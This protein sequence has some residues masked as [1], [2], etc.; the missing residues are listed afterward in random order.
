MRRLVRA[1]FHIDVFLLN[2]TIGIRT[3]CEDWFGWSS[4]S[5]ER[6]LI[7]VYAVT[8]QNLLLHPHPSRVETSL[9]WLA[10]A[11][12]IFVS[13]MMWREQ[14]E[15]EAKRWVRLMAPGMTPL[16]V[17]CAGLAVVCVADAIATHDLIGDMPMVAYAAFQYML[18]IPSGGGRRGRKRKLALAKLR[19]MFGSWLPAPAGNPA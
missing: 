16:R 10:S 13:A 5:M 9:A 11:F 8:G 19:E 1:T 7:V 17:S 2:R 15:P 3:F 6:G 12:V 18:A 14:K 4:R